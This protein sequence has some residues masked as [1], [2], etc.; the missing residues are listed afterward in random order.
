[1]SREA[2]LQRV[3]EAAQRGRAWRVERHEVPEGTGYVGAGDDLPARIAAE[4]TAVG[5]TSYLVADLNEARDTLATLLQKFQP[6]R[7]LLWEHPLLDRLEVAQLLASRNIDA[8]DHADLVQLDRPA[9]RE[10]S[11]AADMGI[12][13]ADWGIAETG[14]L[15]MRARPG[16][17]RLASL[18]P[19]VHVAI[20]ERS[21]LAADLLDVFELLQAEGLDNL[22]SNI[23]LITGPSKTG[24]IELQLTTGVHG[25]GEWHVIVAR[26]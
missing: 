8:V 14:T 9:Q 24:D 15:V 3:R 7:A 20:V 18:L 25:P 12:T 23:T 10:Q 17:E 16:Q 19:P 1:M 4:V 26:R 5:G 22:P 11:L 21:Q 13:S 6:R 2:F